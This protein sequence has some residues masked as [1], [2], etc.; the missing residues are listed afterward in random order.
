VGAHPEDVHPPG[1]QLRDEQ[2]VQAPEHNRVHSEEITRQQALR[3]SPKE[4]APGGVQVAGSGP[5]AA[6]AEDP[7]DGRLAERAAKAGQFAVDAAVT[8]SWVLPCQP[9]HQ[10]ADLLAG[11]SCTSPAFCIA[12]GYRNSRILAATWNG[13]RGSVTNNATH[14]VNN[15]G[16]VA[17]TSPVFRVSP[18]FVSSPWIRRY[19]HS[20]V[21]FRQPNGQA[22]CPVPSDLRWRQAA[23][24][25][26]L[27]LSGKALDGCGADLPTDV[28]YFGERRGAGHP[29]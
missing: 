6:G 9:Q 14:N 7:A 28:R 21:L 13:I 25:G 26:C 27:S 8:P 20:G 19:P 15:V 16:A 2:H 5:V 17:F 10:P 18:G 22:S 23:D 1:R 12:F 11:L 29:A 24:L 4:G 3:L